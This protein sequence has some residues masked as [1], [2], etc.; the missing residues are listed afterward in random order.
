[1]E[2]ELAVVVFVLE[3]SEEEDAEGG[4]DEEEET[5]PP[6]PKIR[7]GLFSGMGGGVSSPARAN[8]VKIKRQFK[9][10]VQNK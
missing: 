6:N 4:G 2:D 7:R 8:K 1:M 3:G 10:S 5:Y 9:P